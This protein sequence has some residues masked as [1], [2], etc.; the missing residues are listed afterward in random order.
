[1]SLASLKMPEPPADPWT[2][3]IEQL[4]R[5]L[6]VAQRE[7]LAELALPPMRRLVDALAQSKV[8]PAIASAALADALAEIKRCIVS[9]ERAP[10]VAV[11]EKLAN[12]TRPLVAPVETPSIAAGPTS[13]P[14][15][16][17]TRETH[18]P[19]RGEAPLA[20]D[21]L[22]ALADGSDD[23]LRSVI[24]SIEDD[25]IP[26]ALPKPRDDLGTLREPLTNGRVLMKGELQAGF[27]TDLIQL[28]TQNRETG[29]VAITGDAE[30][31]IY[32]ADGQVVDATAGDRVGEKAFY[33]LMQLSR[34]R[35]AYQR[36]A[37]ATQVRIARRTQH[38]IMDTL[39]MI[40]EASQ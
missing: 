31:E 17:L 19:P 10:D 11:F 29:R 14:P 3:R 34:G 23:D 35:F 6:G 28:F 30:G 20:L 33:Y 22:A 39:R 15:P 27:L 26:A 5:G 18:M 38:L 1:M 21:M 32:L 37:I 24:D 25:A 9:P 40:D 2:Q 12:I 7:S 16:Q 8:T 4:E 36:G 13:P